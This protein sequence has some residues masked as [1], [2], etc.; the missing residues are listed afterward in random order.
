LE[1]EPIELSTFRK[2]NKTFF[3]LK[4][5]VPDLILGY[6]Y[7]SESFEIYRKAVPVKKTDRLDFVA[8]KANTQQYGELRKDSIF[9]H[10][11]FYAEP[12]SKDEYSQYYT[13]SGKYGL[14]DGLKGSLN[15]RDGRWQGY[16]GIDMNITLEWEEVQKFKEIK[17]SYYQYN[18]AWIFIPTEVECSISKN[19][20]KWY[21]QKLV[22]RKIDPEERGK[23][24]YT[25]K[26]RK[27]NGKKFKYVRIMAKN[28]GEVPEWHEAAGSEAWIFADEIIIY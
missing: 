1:A 28:L 24:R 3:E 25:F 14:M 8:I 4:G 10:L 17:T 20:K 21:S 2:A 9:H 13:A 11:G 22:N 18:N 23:M 12:T 5:G 6:Y 15:F 26:F 7:Q 16:S 27:L 19:G